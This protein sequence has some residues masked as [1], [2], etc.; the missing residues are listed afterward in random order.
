MTT[1]V[2]DFRNHRNNLSQILWKSTR[3]A[4]RH[5]YRLANYSPHHAQ[6]LASACAC[7][8]PS[9][10]QKNA[11]RLLQLVTQDLEYTTP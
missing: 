9:H 10:Q 2:L 1:R 7:A 11:L 3:K 5:P 4:Q 8:I 6:W